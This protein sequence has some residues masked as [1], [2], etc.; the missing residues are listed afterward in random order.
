MISED[1]EVNDASESD[2]M[3]D[4]IMYKVSI[5]SKYLFEF[6]RIRSMQWFLMVR[7]QKAATFSGIFIPSCFCHNA[8]MASWTASDA[9][10]GSRRIA[11]AAA[12]I[13]RYCGSNILLNSL[14]VIFMSD[15]LLY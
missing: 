14:S 13:C 15:D 9:S 10:S 5:L 6:R 8:E 3:S 7:L 12:Y 4:G 1:V 2:A 11:N